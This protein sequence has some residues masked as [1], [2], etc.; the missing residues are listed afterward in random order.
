MSERIR[1]QLLEAVSRAY[2]A[3]GRCEVEEAQVE[4]A[5][6]LDILQRA[7]MEQ[8][9]RISPGSAIFYMQKAG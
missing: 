6:I 3:L 5:K 7:E 2:I 1:G 9:V 8:G 4:M